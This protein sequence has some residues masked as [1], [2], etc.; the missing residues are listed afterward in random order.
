MDMKTR[1]LHGD[2][3]EEMYM[4]QPT[5]FVAKGKKEKV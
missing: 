5:G 1:I 2:L 3:E 4:K